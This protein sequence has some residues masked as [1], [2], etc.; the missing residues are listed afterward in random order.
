MTVQALAVIPDKDFTVEHLKHEHLK[1][2][3]TSGYSPALTVGDFIFIPGITSM[4]VGDEPRRNGIAA[5]A[6]K[7]GGAQWGGQP[8]NLGTAFIITQRIVP[9]L[10]PVG[11]RLEDCAHAP[12]YLSNRGDF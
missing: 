4:A 5:A 7:A 1:G 12:I 10:K 3:P 11:P 8:N 2:R 9:A 6:L